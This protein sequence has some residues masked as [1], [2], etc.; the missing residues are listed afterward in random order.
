MEAPELKCTVCGK[1]LEGSYLNVKG[2]LY[3]KE[4]FVCAKCQKPMTKF[5]TVDGKVYCDECHDKIKQPDIFCAKCEKIIEGDYIIALGK[6]W[7]IGCLLCAK[8]EK[9]ID[10]NYVEA[11]GHV[12]CSSECANTMTGKVCAECGKP[13]S[14]KYLTILDRPYH[15]ECYCCHKCKKKFED[16]S[17]FP[18]DGK[19]YCEKC[20]NKKLKK[21]EKKE[22][23]EKEEK[24]K[25]EKEEKEEK[26]GGPSIS[27][28]ITRN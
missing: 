26:K 17:C 22:K 8:C 11:D 24:E 2:N 10:T 18:V 12:F 23:K 15:K 6:D 13:V 4:C 9:A 5:F 7:H 14:G 28:T 21:K 20:A 16:M 3:H 25:K 19:P 27:V 1:E